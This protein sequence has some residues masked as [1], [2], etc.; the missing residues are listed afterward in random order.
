VA[1]PSAW[2][3]ALTTAIPNHLH[4]SELKKTSEQ[5]QELYQQA[6]LSRTQ[7]IPFC[8]TIN[9]SSR[10]VSDSIII[11]IVVIITIINII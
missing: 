1:A 4:D 11:I 6:C 8:P 2:R 9:I 3:Y 10:L 7:Q 5:K